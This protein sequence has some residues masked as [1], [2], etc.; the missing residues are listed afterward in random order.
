M[1]WWQFATCDNGTVSQSVVFLR[2]HTA[3]L[4]INA[5]RDIDQPD[6][7]FTRSVE[8]GSRKA[9]EREQKAG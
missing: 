7:G 5:D 4:L 2:E 9:K 1:S 6:R 3:V 8:N